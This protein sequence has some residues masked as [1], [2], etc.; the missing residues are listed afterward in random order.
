MKRNYVLAGLVI[1]LVAVTLY[2][3]SY[4]G[5]S[6][7][8]ISGQAYLSPGESTQVSFDFS[9][10]VIS[11][12]DG[13]ALP[14]SVSVDNG[15]IVSTAGPFNGFYAVIIMGSHEVATIT[16][17]YTFPLS[18]KYALVNAGTSTLVYGAMSLLSVVLGVVGIVLVVLGVL[19]GRRRE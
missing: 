7:N 11:Y 19:R 4:L 16:N 2:F 6:S 3:V 12:S 8:V 10:A 18:V 14:L 1:L 15:Q 17:N 5:T 9:E 13:R